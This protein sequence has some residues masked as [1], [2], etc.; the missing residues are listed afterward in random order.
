MSFEAARRIDQGLAGDVEDSGFPSLALGE[1]DAVY[2]V[3]ELSP[4]A[5]EPPRGL[6]FAVVNSRIEPGEASRLRL[7]AGRDTMR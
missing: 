2:L 7:V 3:W 5:G 4:E 6:G 1:S